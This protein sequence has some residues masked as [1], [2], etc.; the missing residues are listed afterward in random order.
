MK[1]AEIKNTKGL[2][3]AIT[4]ANDDDLIGWFVTRYE[5]DKISAGPYESKVLAERAAK[6]STW[7]VKS[8]ND[9]YIE[10]GYQDDDEVFH[11]IEPSDR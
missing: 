3:E 4:V 5:G 8:P 10:Y 2:G 1:L 9:F 11:I 6:A 7:Y